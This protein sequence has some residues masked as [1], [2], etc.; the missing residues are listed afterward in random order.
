VRLSRLRL[1][2]GGGGRRG[3]LAREV[4]DK[5]FERTQVASHL[6][7]L[8]SRLAFWVGAQALDPR[9]NLLEGGGEFCI[10]G[11]A[12]AEIAG[13]NGADGLVETVDAI[14]EGVEA[15]TAR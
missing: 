8:V 3:Q 14:S 11:A 6:V 5:A 13:A 10:A 2:L 4:L 12:R 7:A 1:T 9:M 15:G